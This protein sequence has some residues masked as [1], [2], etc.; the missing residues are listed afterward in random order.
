[1]I[2]AVSPVR[3]R[4]GGEWA[5]LDGMQLRVHRVQGLPKMVPTERLS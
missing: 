5:A 4:R 2:V 3:R 1:M